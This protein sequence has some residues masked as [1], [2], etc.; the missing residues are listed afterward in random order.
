MGI[1][2]EKALVFGVYSTAPDLWKLAI[3]LALILA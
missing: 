2:R 3:D 1:L